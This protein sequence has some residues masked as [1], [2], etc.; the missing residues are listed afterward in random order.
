ME[1]EFWKQKAAVKWVVEGERNT[2]YFHGLVKQKRC[3]GRIHYI[4]DNGQKLTKDADLQAS[5]AKFFQQHLSNDVTNLAPAELVGLQALPNGLDRLNLC[6]Y[7]STQEIKEAV[8]GINANSVSGPDGF[9][10]H[11]YHSCWEIVHT[12]IED[13]VMDFFNGHDMPWSFTATTIIL[14]PKTEHPCNWSEY[15]P[16]SLCNVTN[17]IISKILNNRLAPLLS[18]LVAPTQSGFTRGRLISDNILLAQELIHDIGTAN[19]HQNVALKLDIAKA[20]DRVQWSFLALVLAKLGF[21]Q[22]WID[23]I[24][25]CVENCWFSV[26]INGVPSGFFK[27]ERGLRQG[28]LLSPTLF[29]LAA[30]VLSRGLDCL[31]QAHPDMFYTT[32]GGL[33][34]THLAYA[35]DIIIFTNTR[36]DSLHLLMQFLRQ[37]SASSGQAINVHKSSFITSH[38]CADDVNQRVHQLTGFNLQRLPVKY[39]GAP[40]YKRHTKG[41]LF[42]DMVHKVRLKLQSWSHKAL[43]FG[44]RLALIKSTLATMPLFLIQV[45]RP[46]KFILH[47][48]EQIMAKFFWGAYGSASDQR[49]IHWVSWAKVCLPVSEGGLGIRKLDDM[50]HAFTCKLWWRF[51]EQ[52]SLWARFLYAKYCKGFAPGEVT[53]SVHD[54]FQWKR[55]CKVSKAVQEQVFWALGAGKVSFWYDNWFGDQPLCQILHRQLMGYY[56]VNFLWQ[57]KRWDFDKLLLILKPRNEEELAVINQICQTPILDIDVDIP[58][59]KLNSQGNFSVASAW[60]FFRQKT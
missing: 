6:N 24:R 35:D 26:L 43:S 8:F 31:F 54:S 44:G 20:Y 13:D 55:M 7:P 27:S 47:T 4:I 10:S 39:L 12:D 56:E 23:F 28:D 21:P 53:P 14:I 57:N 49:K 16:I 50:V 11:F 46:P 9:S 60:A 42:L 30:E 51:R 40:L 33:P 1:E 41:A 25:K 19:E 52:S 36:D 2:R 59:W 45:L 58:R 3:R 15:R 18:S 48:L 5:G 38:R 32:R 29:V 22:R 34:I 17:K 37:Y